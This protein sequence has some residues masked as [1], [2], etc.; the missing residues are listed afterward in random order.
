MLQ[1]A[2]ME[3]GGQMNSSIDRGTYLLWDMEFNPWVS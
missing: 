1:D 3:K 2:S